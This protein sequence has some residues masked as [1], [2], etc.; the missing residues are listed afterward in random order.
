MFPSWRP[1]Q[2]RTLDLFGRWGDSR[3]QLR[4]MMDGILPVAVVDRFRNDDEGS[5]Y[6]IN[7]FAFSVANEFPSVSFG[8][9]VNDWELL[10]VNGLAPNYNG[11]GGARVKTFHIFTPVDPYN[12]ATTINP[13]GFFVPGLITNQAFT[14][15]TVRGIGGSNPALPTV[16]GPGFGGPLNVITAITWSVQVAD[17]GEGMLRYPIRV[18]RDTTLTIQYSGTLPAGIPV[19]MALSIMYRE[20]PKVNA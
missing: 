3:T 4:S 19:D 1:I 16:L 11:A 20:R 10:Q 6:G 15:G 5:V 9:A 12:P 7:A 8:S 2:K 14:L 13:V 17:W 18:Y